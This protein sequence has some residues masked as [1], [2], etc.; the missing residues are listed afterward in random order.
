[1][2]FLAVCML[3]LIS[4]IVI[5][6]N[7]N[8]L[9]KPQETVYLD[10]MNIDV[11]VHHMTF[12]G[13]IHNMTQVRYYIRNDAKGDFKYEPDYQPK[14]LNARVRVDTIKVNS[15]WFI[16]SDVKAIL[17][18]FF[19]VFLISLWIDEFKTWYHKRKAKQK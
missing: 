10:D 3:F 2:V 11:I 12:M 4:V 14:A 18:Y 17:G 9:I 13:L 15:G 5:N 8:S 1:M 6:A 19:T 7:V 16:A